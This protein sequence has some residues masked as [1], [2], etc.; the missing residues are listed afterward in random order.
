MLRKLTAA[1]YVLL[2]V[3]MAAAT[4][5]EARCGTP[6]AHE[7][8]Y[9]AWWFSLLWALLA[10]AGIGWIV[11]RRMRRIS[12]LLLHAS[13]A[14]ILLGAFITHVSAQRGTIHLRLHEPTST[15]VVED[16]EGHKESRPLPFSLT[17]TSFRI[18]YHPGTTSV[19]DYVSTF[20]LSEPPEA[21]RLSADANQDKDGTREGRVSMNRI[22]THHAARLY[23]LSYDAD[24]QGSYLLLNRDPW[25]I[26]ITYCGYAL[27][28]L[29]LLWML[30]DPRGSFRRLLASDTLRRGLLLLALMSGTGVS[31]ADT[32]VL[33]K[34]TAEDFGRLY[35]HYNGRIC[36]VQTLA[37]DFTKK[38]CGK[39][40]YRD[41]TAEQVLTGFLLWPEEWSQEPVI[42]LKKAALREDFGLPRHT[43]LASFF[44]QEAG[45]YRLAALV[46][47]YY[48]GHH[49]ALHQ[50]AADIDARLQ[51]I[52]DL[53][54]GRLLPLFPYSIIEA[55]DEGHPSLTTTWYAPT[56]SLPATMEPERARYI[57]DILPLLREEV[58]QGKTK[59]GRELI[60]KLKGYQQRFA[61]SSLPSPTQEKAERLYNA[62]PLPTILFMVD[63]T[64]G[65]LLLLWVIIRMS[66]RGSATGQ[67][68]RSRQAVRR[69]RIVSVCFQLLLLLSFLALTLCLALR[70]EISG[71]VP[72]ANGYET[73]LLTAWLLQL[74]T[75]IACHRLPVVLP[76]G[77]LLS[78]CFLLVSHI[79]QMDPQITHI[80]PVLSSPLLTIHVSLVMMAY[81]LLSMTFICALTALILRKTEAP[82]A[83]HQL[84]LLFLFPALAFLAMGIFIGAVW[85]N[86]S[87]GTYWS[88]DPKET[89]ALITLLVYAIPAHSRTIPGLRRPLP[90]HLFMLIAFLS[91][92]MTY[93][94]VNYVLGGM[95][96]YA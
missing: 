84:S 22:F 83:L 16:K 11:K 78:G 90:F 31:L 43:S 74:L 33:P 65:L 52:F 77:L 72:M 19:A 18:I 87:W 23:Q 40:H 92:L 89:W 26:G 32:P 88:W 53:C 25:G 6:F 27:L 73:M 94:G 13:L 63:L 56:D 34:E 59:E 95:H 3:V 30:L 12:L 35:V 62:L 51:L 14:L 44:S 8:F 41:Y 70:W 42:R 91:L 85:A 37:I 17:L 80:M 68:E 20:T 96:S 2:L 46:Q 7:H 47:E 5:V 75:L 50:Q 48:R 1:F 28:F 79:S 24:G 86:V 4:V 36:P 82:A 49:D 76:F 67:E 55:E 57:R 69:R 10:V 29:S 9:G 54:S 38:L 66:R 60:R 64:A 21:A 81:A 71:T 93:F 58:Q 15:F 45:G 61:G 39:D